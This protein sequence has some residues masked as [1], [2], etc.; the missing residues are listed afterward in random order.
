VATVTG[1]EVLAV[2]ETYYDQL[3]KL[4]REGLL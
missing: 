1:P 2:H 4:R 3:G